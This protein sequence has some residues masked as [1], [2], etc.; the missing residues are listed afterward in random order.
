MEKKKITLTLVV[1]AAILACCLVK[2]LPASAHDFPSKIEDWNEDDWRAWNDLWDDYWK[3]YYQ[4]WNWA[5]NNNYY[6][7]PPNNNYYN[8]NSNSN[9]YSG[10]NFSSGIL[11]I[12]DSGTESQAQTLARI[13]N[14]YA[15][16][17]PSITAQACVGWAVINSVD[18]SG[19]GVDINSVAGNF[20][21]DPG[22]PTSDDF[23]RDL[24]PL[25]RDI[26]FR[27]KAGK[28]GVN[29]Y[30]V[31]PGGYCW[32][33]S[34]GNSVVFRNTPDESGAPW[35]YAYASPYGG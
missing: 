7:Y 28:S 10:Y 2:P 35:N 24:M 5:N 33:W 22:R 3:V 14:L 13:I 26:I 4:N 20:H 1:A 6:Y 27:W 18:A 34:T 29:S 32:V 31:L 16:G 9:S 30:R 15:H 17:V 12:Y 19:Y 8:S 23:G 21:Y 11:N 25:A